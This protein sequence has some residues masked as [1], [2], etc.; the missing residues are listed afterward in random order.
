MGKRGRRRE[1][2]R[3]NVSGARE[4]ANTMHAMAKAHY[5][6]TNPLVLEALEQ[7]AEALGGTFKAQNVANTLWAYATMGQEPGAG[8]MRGREGRA[9]AVAGTFNAQ[10]VANTLW[11][12]AT[13][14]REPGAGM[15]RGLEGR[16]E[17]LGGTFNSQGVANTLWAYV[18]VRMRRWGGSPGRE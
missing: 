16:A 10:N 2:E 9:E 8:V 13:M 1:K 14:G 7:R 18:C 6:P 5:T 12:Y 3:N 15:M 4:I 17:A 11:A